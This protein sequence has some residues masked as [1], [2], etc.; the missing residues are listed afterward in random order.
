MEL[1]QQLLAKIGIAL[2]RALPYEPIPL[3]QIQRDTEE[4]TQLYL[5]M[6]EEGFVIVSLPDN[7]KEIEDMYEVG[8]AFLHASTEVKEAHLDPKD[9]N[10]GYVDI[11]GVRQYIK[12]RI[13]GDRTGQW[14]A[15]PPDFKEKY[16]KA[17]Q[18][19][20]DVAWKVFIEILHLSH[21]EPTRLSEPFGDDVLLSVQD[22]V[23]QMSSVSVIHYYPQSGG[24]VSTSSPPSSS[25]TPSPP[26]PPPT[27]IMEETEMPSPAL[28]LAPTPT[29]EQ[30]PAPAPTP[31]VI[32]VPD[33]KNA[34]G[35]RDV[36]D[37]HTDT[38]ILTVIVCS[39]VP[40]LQVWDRKNNDWLPV[41]KLLL[42]TC[43]KE[44]E[45]LAICIMGEKMGLFTDVLT[46]TLHRVMVQPNTVR[47]SMLYFMDTAK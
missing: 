36:C 45:H 31:T 22:C 32:P 38:G 16:D 5:H 26:P 19:L 10:L 17:S 35:L 39:R 24:E 2:T 7:Y 9:E 8:A 47:Y 41:E 20:H 43:K 25:S 15:Q 27:T 30:A 37:A 11:A 1:I 40:G 6:K 42:E 21:L 14:P 44:G 29:E 34:Y 13:T 33:D 23:T 4:T 46:A 18:V 3:A 12:L 28:A